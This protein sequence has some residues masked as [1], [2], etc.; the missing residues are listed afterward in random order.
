M[1]PCCCLSSTC[2][3]L[4]PLTPLHRL[5][6][7]RPLTASAFSIGA[8]ARRRGAGNREDV[9][10]VRP[11][12][13]ERVCHVLAQG[14][15]TAAARAPRD[16]LASDE[17]RRFPRGLALLARHPQPHPGPRDGASGVGGR[18]DGCAF[19]ASASRSRALARYSQSRAFS[20]PSP[21][22]AQ[23]IGT[24]AS[25]DQER[26]NIHVRPAAARHTAHAESQ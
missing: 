2:T 7:S 19:S 8:L 10:R 6:S 22:M 23:C 20:V 17:G 5:L 3:L 11:R 21:L 1:V 24:A 13:A 9:L 16:P 14:T 25:R 12:R 15:G 18:D 4:T 26:L